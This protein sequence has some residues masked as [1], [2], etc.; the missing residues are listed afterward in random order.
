MH[1]D[2][3]KSRFNSHSINLAFSKKMGSFF[4]FTFCYLFSPSLT[5]FSLTYQIKGHLIQGRCPN[6]YGVNEGV[7]SI[8]SVWEEY[9]FL[10]Y[11]KNKT[12]KICFNFFLTKRERERQRHSHTHAPIILRYKTTTWPL[13][14]ELIFYK[15]KKLI[16]LT[17]FSGV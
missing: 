14:I 16:I 11:R 13:G 3:A 9:L 8:S 4:F 12:L 6:I 1:P 7:M 2:V 5:A 17:K 15:G 10:S